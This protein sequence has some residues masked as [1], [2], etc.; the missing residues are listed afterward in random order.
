MLGRNVLLIG[1]GALLTL[2]MIYGPIEVLGNLVGELVEK[3]KGD[4]IEWT[5]RLIF[6]ETS[7]AYAWVPVSMRYSQ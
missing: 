1:E 6:E 2:S 3:V 5:L 7:S 4:I